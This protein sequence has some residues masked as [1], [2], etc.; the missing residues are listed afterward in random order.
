MKLKEYL[1]ELPQ[2]KRV[3][4]GFEHGT[5][6]IYAGEAFDGFDA[7]MDMISVAEFDRH[8][9]RKKEL[10]RKLSN[11]GN[12]LK[13][14]IVKRVMAKFSNTL[15]LS[16]KSMDLEKDE[17]PKEV[18]AKFYKCCDECRTY[19]LT[20]AKENYASVCKELTKKPFG[21]MDREIVEEYASIDEIGTIIVILDGDWSGKYWSTKE[22]KNDSDMQK[23]IDGIIRKR[24]SHKK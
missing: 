8:E 20:R 22:C 6:F 11:N 3:K 1:A 17:F 16:M 2:G 4:I 5:N 24:E 19:E 14:D 7:L 10:E 9:K 18:A 21:A 15:L 12:G 13:P 23:K